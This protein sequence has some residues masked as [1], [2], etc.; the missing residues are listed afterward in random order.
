MSCPNI[1]HPLLLSLLFHSC[2]SVTLSLAFLYFSKASHLYKFLSLSLPSSS[3]QSVTCAHTW[4]RVACILVLISARVGYIELLYCFGLISLMACLL[5]QP[6]LCHTAVWVWQYWSEH[7]N[8]SVCLFEMTMKH[9]LFF[10]DKSPSLIFLNTWVISKVLH[11][12]C[13]LFKNEFILQNT[14]AGLQ[15]NLHCALSQRSNVWESLVFLSGRLRCWCVWLLSS[16][17]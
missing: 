12:V 11:T 17:H 13:F 2:R 10:I 16:P 4:I 3:C 15:C 9:V 7:K 1:L 8:M 6:S 5:S 14:F